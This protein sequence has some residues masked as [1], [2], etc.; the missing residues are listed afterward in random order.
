MR[1]AD[2]KQFDRIKKAIETKG[3]TPG[4]GRALCLPTIFRSWGC[5]VMW[6]LLLVEYYSLAPP[7]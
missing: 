7:H 2:Q 6:T 3:A 4:G 1:I 5:L